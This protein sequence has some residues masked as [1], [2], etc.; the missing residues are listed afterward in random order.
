M[1]IAL[2]S[3][4]SEC[5]DVVSSSFPSLKEPRFIEPVGLQINNE[6]NLDDLWRLIVN[7]RGSAHTQTITLPPTA[8]RLSIFSVCWK[9][10]GWTYSVVDEIMEMDQRSNDDEK[11]VNEVVTN[12]KKMD[13]GPWVH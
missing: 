6:V 11:Q 2:G 1:M 5:V 9:Q 3:A 8:E 10:S 12:V 4:P 7:G 13:R